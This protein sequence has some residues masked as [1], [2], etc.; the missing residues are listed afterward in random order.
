MYNDIWRKTYSL[1]FSEPWIS[2]KSVCYCAIPLKTMALSR[3]CVISLLQFMKSLKIIALETLFLPMMKHTLTIKTLN[4][5]LSGTVSQ[6][7]LSILQ[8]GEFC[9][10]LSSVMTVM[11]LFSPV[12]RKS[13]T[14]MSVNGCSTCG[15]L[16]YLPSAVTVTRLQLKQNTT[17]NVWQNSAIEWS[18]NGMMKRAKRNYSQLW[19]VMSFSVNKWLLYF[20]LL[21][22]HYAFAKMLFIQPHSL[23]AYKL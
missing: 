8:C 5:L 12:S 19:N 1:C 4:I 22:T 14:S 3:Y 9:W 20:V 16:S 18:R 10:L 2:Q 21:Y 17:S 13:W 23:S 11:R 15:N 7:N 6:E